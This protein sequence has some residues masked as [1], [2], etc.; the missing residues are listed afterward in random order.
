MKMRL[1]IGSGIYMERDGKFSVCHTS[2]GCKQTWVRGLLTLKAA[3]A[4]KLKLVAEMLYIKRNLIAER[5][6][7]MT[8]PPPGEWQRKR[9]DF[10]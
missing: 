6:M 2:P 3:K 9:G 4:V 10:R 5:F 7:N 8:T 1:S